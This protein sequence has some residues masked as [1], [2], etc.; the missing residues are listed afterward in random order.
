MSNMA[1]NDG[2]IDFSDIL[3]DH[4]F[5]LAVSG[6]KKTFT[7][8]ISKPLDTRREF[9]SMLKIEDYG[10]CGFQF[11]FSILRSGIKDYSIRSNF[12][13]LPSSEEKWRKCITNGTFSSS[14]HIIWGIT[15][16]AGFLS[17]LE[18]V[19]TEEELFFLLATL[20]EWV[21]NA[22]NGP[23]GPKSACF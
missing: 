22:R 1:S 13:D 18:N 6:T 16:V 15:S 10:I 21:D 17:S 7:I 8:T 4:G 5:S 12:L 19:I 11:A 3:L 20:V 14:G 23:S 2:M 9:R